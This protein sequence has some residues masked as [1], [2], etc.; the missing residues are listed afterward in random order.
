MLDRPAALPVSTETERPGTAPPVSRAWLVEG[1]AR[2]GKVDV[3]VS[4]ASTR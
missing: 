4:S 1:Q 3:V 2:R